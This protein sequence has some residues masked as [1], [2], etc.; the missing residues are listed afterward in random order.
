MGVADSSRTY[1]AFT[2][3]AT[4]DLVSVA[5]VWYS[6][7][8]RMLPDE[9]DEFDKICPP[10]LPRAR[11]SSGAVG[12]RGG[13][14]HRGREG[15]PRG[16]DRG[17]AP[18]PATTIR[19]VNLQLDIRDVPRAS[20]KDYPE[21]AETDEDDVTGPMERAEFQVRRNNEVD[22]MLGD[23]LPLYEGKLPRGAN[24][25][26]FL[27]ARKRS[28]GSKKEQQPAKGQALVETKKKSSPTG[29][30]SPVTMKKAK[31]PPSPTKEGKPP[32][33]P[34]G[35]SSSSAGTAT[36]RPSGA[37]DAGDVETV[38]LACPV[39]KWVRIEQK[40]RGSEAAVEVERT[41]GRILSEGQGTHLPDVVEFF[42][43]RATRFHESPKHSAVRPPKN[44]GGLQ[45]ADEDGAR[46]LVRSR[47]TS[48]SFFLSTERD[49]SLREKALNGGDA[50]KTPAAV[51]SEHPST[52]FSLVSSQ[53][54]CFV[55]L[56]GARSQSRSPS[57][58]ADFLGGAG[59]KMDVVELQQHAS[60]DTNGKRANRAL[61]QSE[62]GR[63]QRTL[64]DNRHAQPEDISP[65][66]GDISGATKKKASFP[67]E[68]EDTS[69]EMVGPSL[70]TFGR[71]EGQ[72]TAEKMRDEST[73]ES[74]C[75]VKGKDYRHSKEG[76]EEGP[77]LVLS[78]RAAQ[79]DKWNRST[80]AEDTSPAERR[81]PTF[82]YGLEDGSEE[83]GGEDVMESTSC[84]LADSEGGAKTLVACDLQKMLRRKEW[85]WDRERAALQCR[86]EG[87]RRERP[88][89]RPERRE[90]ASKVEKED[91][92]TPLVWSRSRGGQHLRRRSFETTS[93][94]TWLGSSN[95]ERTR[96]RS[97]TTVPSYAPSPLDG[98][99]LV[100]GNGR[101]SKQQQQQSPRLGGDSSKYLL[102][103][104]RHEGEFDESCVHAAG[105]DSVRSRE[106][107]VIK[108]A[109]DAT[110]QSC[111]PHTSTTTTGG[112]RPTT[113]STA[114]LSDSSASSTGRGRSSSACSTSSDCEFDAED[115]GVR[116]QR[117]VRRVREADIST[118]RRKAATESSSYA[119]EAE[120]LSP[121]CRD[122]AVSPIFRRDSEREVLE[123]RCRRF[124][125]QERSGSSSGDL[126]DSFCRERVL[127]E[128]RP[129]DIRSEDD[130]HLGSP[131]LNSSRRGSHHP[132]PSVS[133]VR[134]LGQSRQYNPRTSP[135]PDGHAARRSFWETEEGTRFTGITTD[136]SEFHH[137]YLLYKRR[138]HL[139][140]LFSAPLSS[141]TPSPR[142]SSFPW[143]DEVIPTCRAAA[144]KGAVGPAAVREG[145]RASTDQ[146]TEGASAS[147]D[148]KRPGQEK[149]RRIPLNEEEGHGSPRRDGVPAGHGEG[150]KNETLRGATLS[151]EKTERNSSHT[152][153]EVNV[154]SDPAET[155]S[156]AS[157]EHTDGG[158][159][160]CGVSAE[161]PRQPPR[162]PFLRR[163]CG[164]GGGRYDRLQNS[165]AGTASSSR[166][167]SIVQDTSSSLRGR[168]LNVSRDSSEHTTRD[169]SELASLRRRSRTVSRNGFASQERYS[170]PGSSSRAVSSVENDSTFS[171]PRCV[172][173]YPSSM[174]RGRDEKNP[175]DRALGM[176][177][178]SQVS[179]P[180]LLSTPHSDAGG[181]CKDLVFSPISVTSSSLGSS[182]S[183]ALARYKDGEFL[184]SDSLLGIGMFPG[185]SSL[186][187][188][189]Q[190]RSWDEVPCLPPRADT[191]EEE[192]GK[193]LE[194]KPFLKKGSGK[195]AGDVVHRG[196][197][198]DS[199]FRYN[200]RGAEGSRGAST[201]GARR[202]ETSK[203]HPRDRTA[204][205]G[206]Q[207]TCHGLSKDVGCTRAREVSP[208]PKRTWK[209]RFA[210]KED[211]STGASRGQ[212]RGRSAE[213]KP[214]D[215]GVR[216]G[217]QME[218]KGARRPRYAECVDL[219]G[220][221]ERPKVHL[222]VPQHIREKITLGL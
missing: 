116:G 47:D 1:V 147:C 200:R 170:G 174:S 110:F 40:I 115:L 53:Q 70:P 8:Y 140:T 164:I 194:R 13:R 192:D 41:S 215:S 196:S 108:S 188:S 176:N 72:D 159:E 125:S 165:Q 103:S 122:R 184:L 222:D 161:Q 5:S 75:G 58:L 97:L 173:P 16:R 146:S 63:G 83:E 28:V 32:S 89:A 80:G 48:R 82:G 177:T 179:A 62:Q 106:V 35:T 59:G 221:F 126:D 33:T 100:G 102:H 68:G 142:P 183:A 12:I 76:H 156:T 96:R 134:L 169:N 168:S 36:A 182:T 123:E 69:I 21:L 141:P 66:A 218:P 187:K 24:H 197:G 191:D 84:S 205:T 45:V 109:F 118:E 172:S 26:F 166:G 127:S 131:C 201:S 128:N 57:P 74:A 11:T 219:S 81:L 15:R 190:P 101:H 2:E 185:R 119:E 186:S 150:D 157:A 9:D 117:V 105:R 104:R 34:S 55:G 149:P 65:A 93:G 85:Q 17:G 155:I 214:S 133:G 91:G 162:Q 160:S 60:F 213:D 99:G 124:D 130:F 135:L 212:S 30:S 163:G 73:G 178:F 95:S 145:E 151:I 217:R 209:A 78:L 202:C 198:K 27:Q 77:C 4:N 144:A 71:M 31:E 113:A 181:H 121:S 22:R 20:D 171:T 56:L 203:E 167:R 175:G 10:A 87:C 64:F 37:D 189:N 206:E 44:K 148:N 50:A 111:D 92:W 79:S 19:D 220:Y 180:S 46:A 153:N 137:R 193:K 195:L 204:H 42:G 216:V 98:A 154:T 88:P 120:E 14:R 136:S 132:P 112:S 211:R 25:Q 152:L 208:R 6:Q 107:R 210:P 86:E 7:D 67:S 38:K 3:C 94:G 29:A 90:S 54:A 143:D 129:T 199:S 207:A 23:L 51:S 158:R 49:F 43:Q 18:T 138:P 61:P 52:D 114:S 139:R 39:Q